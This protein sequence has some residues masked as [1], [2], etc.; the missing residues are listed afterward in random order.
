MTAKQARAAYRLLTVLA[1][2]D[3]TL[4]KRVSIVVNP[5][6]RKVWGYYYARPHRIEINSHVTDG[7][8]LLRVMA[9]EMCHAVLETSAA[10]DHHKHDMQ[11]KRLARKIMHRMGWKDDI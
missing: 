10:S 11:F 9:H 8:L 6:L 5:R 2:S 4:P 1:F 7:T 3:L